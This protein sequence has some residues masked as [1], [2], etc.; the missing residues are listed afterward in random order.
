[1]RISRKGSLCPVTVVSNEWSTL[2]KREKRWG[3]VYRRCLSIAEYGI[4][5]HSDKRLIARTNRLAKP[6]LSSF[7]MRLLRNLSEKILRSVKKDFL[8]SDVSY[9][10]AASRFG[11]NSDLVVELAVA[12]RKKKQLIRIHNGLTLREINNELNKS[13]EKK[14]SRLL[15]IRSLLLRPSRLVASVYPFI[16]IVSI[17]IPVESNLDST[18]ITSA[19]T[20]R[21]VMRRLR[22]SY[23]L[24]VQRRVRRSPNTYVPR[25]QKIYYAISMLR[26][27]R[28]RKPF[29]SSVGRAK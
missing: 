13:I 11:S 15:N 18:I 25:F 22:F 8:L 6:Y 10:H 21:A 7:G 27:K 3:C 26:Y 19:D 24:F 12:S 23:M 17:G 2:D 29:C 5:R 28:L 16:V 9:F 14:S 20:M 4:S 1:M